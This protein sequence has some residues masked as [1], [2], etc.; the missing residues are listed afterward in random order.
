MSAPSFPPL[1]VIGAESLAVS[2]IDC[3]AVHVV[4]F[5]AKGEV[6]ILYA[7]R[8]SYYKLPGGGIEP[9]EDH[10]TA[11]KLSYCYDADLVDG[12]GEPS[13]TEEIDDGLG[14]LWVPVEEA[15]R[16]VA[17]AGPISDFG[18]PVKERDIYLLDRATRKE[19]GYSAPLL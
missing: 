2:Y 11:A 12:S 6:A 7:K 14:H 17:A 19:S 10:K 16:L 18:R 9:G 3:Q 5:N 15:K 1:K 8:E 13:L 4:A